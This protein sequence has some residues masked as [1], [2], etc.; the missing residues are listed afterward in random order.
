MSDAEAT[1]PRVFIARHGETEWAKIGRFTGITDIELTEH[2][3]KQ[4]S[5]TAAQLVGRGK[6]L[7]PSKVAHICVSPRKRAQQTYEILFAGGEPAIEGQRVTVT[8]DIAEWGYG[9]YEG[10]KAEEIRATRKAKGLDQDK[11][12]DMWR[13]GCEGGESAQDVCTRLDRL[14]SQIR[15]VQRP[16]M[17]GEGHADVVVVAHGAILRAFVKRWL[18]FP[19]DMPLN[20]MFEPGAI[21]VL[22]YKNNNIRQPALLVGMALPP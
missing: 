8:E 5:T 7:D 11:P 16:C 1:T 20:L 22:S 13:D 3:I 12:W 10:L 9:D 17:T 2:G 15:D 4:V 6:L 18:H 19:L 21:G 14:I